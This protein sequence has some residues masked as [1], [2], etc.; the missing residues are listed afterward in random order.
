MQFGREDWSVLIEKLFKR[1]HLPA[2]LDYLVK[3]RVT[4]ARSEE[5]EKK[6]N[7]DNIAR[8][9]AHNFEIEAVFG[10]EADK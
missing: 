4:V 3:P 1:V 8:R 9:I 7:D 5:E 10:Y 6:T 2:I